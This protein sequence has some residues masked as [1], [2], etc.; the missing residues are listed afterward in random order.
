MYHT[1]LLS[2]TSIEEVGHFLGHIPNNADSDELFQTINTINISEKKYKK[3]LSF[4]QN[5]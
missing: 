5:K 1:H 3:T 4:N 2:L